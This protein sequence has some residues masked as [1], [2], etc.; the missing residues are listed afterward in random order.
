MLTFAQNSRRATANARGGIGSLTGSVVALGAAY[1]S[2][3]ASA[4]LF[5]KTIAEAARHE[6][7]VV[8]VEAMFGKGYEK[9]AEDYLSFM[10]E[11]ANI[12]PYDIG[13][14]LGSSK[15]FIA[16]SKELGQLKQMTNLAERL[17][18][19]DPVQGYEG[20]ALALKEFFSGDTQSLVERFE[21]SRSDLKPLKNL[22]LDTQ[23]RELDKFLEKLGASN[24]LLKAQE[25]T[26]MG[27]YLQTVGKIKTALR[28]MGTNGLDY[29]KPMMQDF[30]K[31]LEGS[32]FKKLKEWGAQAFGGLVEGAVN[33][34]RQATNYINTNFINNPEFAK[35]PTLTGKIEF[36]FDNLM[37]TFNAWWSSTGKTNFTSIVSDII[38]FIGDSLAASAPE[39]IAAASKVGAA[40]AQGIMDGIK[41]NFNPFSAISPALKGDKY[42]NNLKGFDEWAAKTPDGQPMIK[43]ETKLVAPKE[44]GF[45]GKAADTVGNAL[46]SFQRSVRGYAGGLDNVPYNNMPARL[47]AG[48]AVLT[49]TEAQEWR[50]NGKQIGGSGGSG[51]PTIVIQNMNVRNDHDIQRIAYELAQY[52][53]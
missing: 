52:L 32:D 3:R 29:I 45:F 24:D 12:S 31:W 21:L 14:F 41:A 25:Q 7:R 23:L 37:A 42:L 40:I 46:S 13:D 4:G 49:K 22:D 50:D 15:G 35:I 20:A 39:I 19:I 2:A 51:T 6:Q 1:L 34:V 16:T 48:E 28:D 44:K 10:Q 43:G 36:I 53:A 30:N 26:T 18:A 27:Q 5:D 17:A 9:T 38:N 47:H 11:R 8:T 33:S